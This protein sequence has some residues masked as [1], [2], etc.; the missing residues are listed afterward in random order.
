MW[1]MIQGSFVCVKIHRISTD[2]FLNSDSLLL[3]NQVR[4]GLN[5]LALA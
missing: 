5:A 1:N 2:L 3:V 4:C